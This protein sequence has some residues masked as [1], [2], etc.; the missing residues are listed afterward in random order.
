NLVTVFLGLQLLAL[1]SYTLVALNRDSPLSSEAAMKYFVLSALASGL[2]LYGM[3]MIYGATGTLDLREIASLIPRAAHP[4]LL[5][6]G[7]IFMVAGITFELGVAPFHMW[8]P[9]VY[10]GAPTAVTNFI[11]SVSKLAAFGLAVRLLQYGL[12][13]LA[14]DWQAMLAV[15][16]ALSMI[17]GNVVAIVQTNLKRMLAYSTIAH[18]GF[19]LLGLVQANGQGYAVAMFYVVCYALMSTAAFGVML[20]LARSGFEAG[21]I[22]DFKGLNKRAPWFAGL[23]AMAMFSLAGI[24]PLWGFWAKLL[25]LRAAIDAGFLWLAITAVVTAIVGLFYYLRVVK[26]MYFD[27]PEPG[28]ELAPVQDLPLRWVLSLNGLA[29]LAVGLYWGPL[30]AW[31]QRAFLG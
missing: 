15:L 1:C 9:D 13:P 22:S 18:M 31:C 21:N 12:Q 11:G 27:D 6:F 23:M 26:V 17:I 10:E 25:V 24:P 2:L 20:A 3:S 16:A 19:V 29:L 8:L 28:S 5:V 14:V 4:N 7:L 30:L